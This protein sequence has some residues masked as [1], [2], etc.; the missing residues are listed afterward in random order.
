MQAG[1]GPNE[2]ATGLDAVGDH[3]IDETMLI[4]KIRS[5]ELSSVVLLI[6]LLEDILEA[7]V[8]SFKNSV[9]GRHVARIVSGEGIL[10]ASMSESIDGLVGVVHAHQDA[11]SWEVEHFEISGLRSILRLE[12]HC[13]LAGHL[14]AEIC[15]SIL[16]SES[17]STDD[18]GLGPARDQSRDVR[19]NDRL[20]EDGATN[21]VPDGS[22]GR[23]PH[24][25]EVEFGDTGLVGGDGCA[26]D[27]NFASLDGL[28]GIDSD[29]VISSVTVLNTQIEVLDVEV[30]MGSDELILDKLP[31]NSGHLVT[32][33]FG[34]G[35]CNLNLL[36][37]CGFGHCIVLSL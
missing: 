21:D 5:L 7:T 2:A 11:R 17:V 22:V 13:E 8:V 23:P 19:D 4:P 9:L 15:G 32:V 25:L 10:H 12:A 16:I 18:D 14:G 20:S 37:W 24:L 34:N 3:I 33:K 31:D 36:S 30:E 6:D 35:V 26:L 1:A 29:L 27:T 28:S